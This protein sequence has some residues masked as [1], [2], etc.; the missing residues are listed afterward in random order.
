MY[1]LPSSSTSAFNHHLIRLHELDI[2]IKHHLRQKHYLR[3]CDDFIFLSDNEQSLKTLIPV[4]E[5]FLK[6]NLHLE[7]HPRKIILRKLS[8]GI[9]FV[10]HVLFQKHQLIRTRTKQRMQR[11]LKEA[12]ANYLE[13][14]S[15][16]KRWIK[17]FSLILEYFPTPTSILSRRLLKMPMDLV[18]KMRCPKRRKAKCS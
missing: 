7:L 18:Q 6:T 10:G 9:D 14:K 5:Q 2:F 3:Y 11:R 15:L 13:E 12:Y 1:M 16:P 4:I 8:Q 17:G